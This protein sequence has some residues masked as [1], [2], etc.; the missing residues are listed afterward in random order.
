M[1]ANEKNAILQVEI[2]KLFRDGDICKLRNKF[3]IDLINEA[4]EDKITLWS[5]EADY[6]LVTHRLAD[7]LRDLGEPVYDLTQNKMLADAFG[8]GRCFLW[9]SVGWA[10][11]TNDVLNKIFSGD[12]DYIRR[13]V[14]DDKRQY[15]TEKALHD[16][17]FNEAIRYATG[18]FRVE[19]VAQ[20]PPSELWI[21]L[22]KTADHIS[23]RD[24]EYFLLWR[25]N[26]DEENDLKEAKIFEVDESFYVEIEGE[27][28]KIYDN[29]LKRKHP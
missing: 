13:K 19:D 10:L 25:H 3:A 7:A 4:S 18:T 11:H 1:N 9:R 6:F 8:K 26:G 21:G 5:G 20:I 16:L 2:N 24:G 17:T 14:I 27:S 23:E 28:L 29:R 12:S 22:F 15:L